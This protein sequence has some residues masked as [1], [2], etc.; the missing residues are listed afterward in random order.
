MNVAHRVLLLWVMRHLLK[1]LVKL[2]NI[3]MQ[4]GIMAPLC[5]FRISFAGSTCSYLLTC[6]QKMRASFVF[7]RSCAMGGG[8]SLEPIPYTAGI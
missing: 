1:E 4:D 6:C 3:R 5:C 8:S 7:R 2:H